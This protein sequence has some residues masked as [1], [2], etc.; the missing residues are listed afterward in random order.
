MG[1]KK[2]KTV[3]F[4][5]F[6]YYCEKDFEDVN[7]LQ[8]HQKLRHFACPSCNKKFCTAFSMSTH[9]LQVHRESV[10]KSFVVTT[11]LIV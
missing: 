1:R 11:Q 3:T 8:Q 2:Q 10:T 5:P 9:A 7:N 4:K 6:C